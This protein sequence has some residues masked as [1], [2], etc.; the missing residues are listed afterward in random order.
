MSTKQKIWGLSA[1]LLLIFLIYGIISGRAFYMISYDAQHVEDKNIPE[2]IHLSNFEKYVLDMQLSI[3]NA[4]IENDTEKLSSAKKYLNKAIEEINIVKELLKNSKDVETINKLE[5]SAKNL[6]IEGEKLAN[7]HIVSSNK[8]ESLKKEI[9]SYEK[10]LHHLEQEITTELDNIE[11]DLKF[12]INEIVEYSKM[13][14]YEGIILLIVGFIVGMII[15]LI[16]IKQI[17]NSLDKFKEGL[18]SF[19]SYLNKESSNVSYLKDDAKDEFGEMSKVVNQNIEKTQKLIV[20]DYDLIE[21]VKRVVKEVKDGKLNQRITKTT[22]NESLEDLKNTFN[23]M[24]ENTSKNVCE[25]INKITRVLNSFAKLDFRDRV[26]NDV[27]IVAKGLNNLAQIINEMLLEN[28]SNGLTLDESSNILLENVNKL[29]ISS[30]EAAAS[31]EETAA[32]IEEITS[33]IRNNTQNIQK[34]ATYSNSVTQSVEQGEKLAN[35]TTLAMEEINTQV[36]SINEAISIIDQIAFQTNILSLNAAVEAATAGEAGKGFAVV[37]QEVRNLASRSAE[38]AREIKK[39]VENATTKANNGKDIANN[40]ICGYKELNGHIQQTMNLIQDIEMSSKE[41]LLGIEQIN[42]AIN[43]LDRQTQQNAQIA[44]QT[45]DVALITDEIA[46]LVVSN[47][48]A[49][50][51]IGKN[52]VKSKKDFIQKK[53]H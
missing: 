49:K 48:N 4:I 5:L 45:H 46:K 50:E 21:D 37:A 29:N 43:S 23:E 13:S 9:E 44:S 18:L 14:L 34:M 36:N 20:Q 16:L 19:F 3:S 31:L 38:A 52:D 30:N 27:G 35:L 39:I 53:K 25:D 6:F 22:Q 15:S 33:N 28:K 17:S 1:S 2:I 12:N 51:F 7:N 40:M 26:E 11:K 47:A 24:L 41:Q 10:S 32:A 42:N 8:N